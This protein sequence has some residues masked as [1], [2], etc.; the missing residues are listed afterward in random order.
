ME[1]QLGKWYKST[2]N[3]LAITE[4]LT[5]TGVRIFLDDGKI[6]VVDKEKFLSDWSMVN[7]ENPDAIKS[8]APTPVYDYGC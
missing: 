4:K 2:T 3:R 6:Q 7:E 1:I 5:S 8:P